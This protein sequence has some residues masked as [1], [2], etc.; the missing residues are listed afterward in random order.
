MNLDSAQLLEQLSQGLLA[1]VGSPAGRATVFVAVM[2]MAVWLLR[3]NSVV[4]RVWAA[5][6]RTIASSWQLALLGSTG[7]ILSV[8]S[9]WTTWDGMRNFTG[10]PILSAMV[11]F[12]IQGVMLIAA[13]LIGESFAAG[14]NRQ[15]AERTASTTLNAAIGA[16]LGI[17]AT[18]ALLYWSLLATGAIAWSVSGR[19]EIDWIR[20]ADTS[21]WFAAAM[22]VVGY[23]AL[24]ARSD[25]ALPYVQSVRIIVRN[26]VLWV[27]FLACM[28]TSVFFSFDSLFTAIFPKEERVRAADLRAQNQVAGIVADIGETIRRRRQLAAEELFSSP[29]WTAYDQQLTRLGAAAQAST[30]EIEKFFNDQIEARNRAIKEQQ[31]RIATSQSTQA[32]LGSKKTTLVEELTR[33]KGERGTLAADFAEKQTELEAR[34]RSVDAKRVEAMAEEKGAEGTLKQGRGPQFQRIM[35]ELAQLQAAQKIQEDRVRDAQKRL[36]TTDSRVAQIQRELATLD[37]D[38]AKLK[39]EA[40]TAEQRIRLTQDQGSDDPAARVDPA[41]VLPAFEAARA[42]FRQKPETAGLL[43]LQQQCTQVVNAMLSTEITKPRVRN[44]DCDPKQTAEAAGVLFALNAGGVRFSEV[45]AGGERLNGLQ[46]A[47]A[48]FGFARKC[49][50]DSGLPSKETDQLRTKIN[51]IELNRD[52]KAHR[53]VVTWN[54]FQDGNRLA[55]L[56]LAIAI[57]IDSLVFMS[58][59]F[60][61]NALRSPLSDVPSSKARSARQL[62]AIIDAALIPHKLDT[63]RLVLGAMRPITL[64]D[65]YMARITL[66]DDDPHAGDIR[67]VLNAGATIGAVRHADRGEHAYEVR[68]E[69]FEYLSQVAKREFES[70]RE[71]VNL[72]EL[73][74]TVSVALLPDVG[75]GASLVLSF[76]HPIREQHGFMAE[77]RMT[78][79]AASTDGA[80]AE[81][82]RVVRTALNAGAMYQRVQ[83]VGED[84]GHYYIHGDFYKVL[85]RLRARMLSSSSPRAA[86]ASAAGRGTLAGGPLSAGMV[87][88]DRTPLD[89]RLTDQTSQQPAARHD[90]PAAGVDWE[91]HCRHALFS[92]LGLSGETAAQRL[93]QPGVREAALAAWMQLNRLTQSS[94]LLRRFL[95]EHKATQEQRVSEVYS[96][97]RSDANGRQDLVDTLDGLAHLIDRELHIIMLFPENG[98]IDYLIDEIEHAARSDNGLLPGEQE[99]HD[100]LVDIRD[101]M[102]A[103]DLGRPDTWQGVTEALRHMVDNQHEILK[104]FTPRAGEA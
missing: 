50:A 74:R 85:V 51:F 46:G 71:H 63:A 13:W 81:G 77:V 72:A 99:L 100:K 10:E 70:N 35:G 83:R 37:G 12:G 80:G 93:N 5:L 102:G 18:V 62:E 27:M 56:A 94:Q 45:C 31:E 88:S 89:Y 75:H 17:A 33:L 30:L 8:A 96:Q 29:A 40:Q 78:E 3:G 41:R 82:E 42:E 44:V 59:L 32:G 49:L 84:A 15:R 65:G 79:V 6:E 2:A 28:A 97:L 23:I 66:S 61:A 57:A 4:V 58:G 68:A 16:L 19:L 73:E 14:M 7:I 11:T 104:R 20:A 98:L 43:K 86:I 25:L 48:L 76:M 9:G 55:Y 1:F 103:S 54:A 52:D 21:L 92:A 53:F 60:G 87:G 26:S 95:D 91:R 101:R 90:E 38:L 24:K 67:R 22:I 64:S 47:D 36:T 69:L 39:G 34:N